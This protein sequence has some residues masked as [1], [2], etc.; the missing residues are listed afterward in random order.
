VSVFDP[1]VLAERVMA[2]ERHLHRVAE[3]LPASASDLQA[4]T[5][6]SDAVILHL[7]QATQIVI[8][9]SMAAC[10]ALKLGTPGSYADAFRRLQAAGVVEETLADRLVRAAGFKNV[11]AHAYESLDMARVHA[12]ARHGPVD[13]RALLAVLADRAK[14]S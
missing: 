6:A 12:A 11:V 5:D 13:L 4:S 10:L 14:E 1:S 9:L 2:V 8:D 7:W 3:R